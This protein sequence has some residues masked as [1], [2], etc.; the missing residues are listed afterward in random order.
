MANNFI[1]RGLIILNINVGSKSLM[2]MP[3]ILVAEGVIEEINSLFLSMTG[4]EEESFIGKRVQYVWKELLKVSIDIGTVELSHQTD[5]FLFDSNGNAKE[6]TIKYSEMVIT[7]K[8]MY[9]FLPKK[10]KMLEE[11]Y[12]LLEKMNS[13]NGVAVALYSVPDMLLLKANDTLFQDH[14]SRFS[15]KF[16]IMGRSLWELVPTVSKSE[17]LD[18]YMYMSKAD[19]SLSI[20]EQKMEFPGIGTRYVDMT[21]TPYFEDGNMKYIIQT[22]SEVTEA[23][24]YRKIL[25]EKNRIIEEQKNQVETIL[26]TVSK[27]VNLLI[28]DKH[29]KFFGDSKMK[30]NYF[31][32]FGNMENIMDTYVP[33]MYYDGEGKEIKLEDMSVSRA[34]RGAVVENE[35]MTMK[36][37]GVTKHYVLNATP[38]YGTN[39]DVIMVI[40][41]GWDITDRIKYQGFVESQRDYM[42]RIFN[43]LQLPIMSMAAS[44]YTVKSINTSAVAILNKYFGMTDSLAIDEI[45]GRKYEDILNV[46]DEISDSDFF[47]RM[48]EKKYDAI[49]ESI[50][51]K[52]GK[53]AIYFNMIFQ[54][55]LNI[56]GEV[57]EILISGV[58]ITSEVKK[59]KEMEQIIKMKDE[60]L[61]LMSHEFKTPLTV[62]NAAI[63]TLEYLYAG[64]IPDKAAL[65]IDKVKLNV[66]RE[67]RL[68]DNLLDITR[69]N[70]GQLKIR[71]KNVDIVYLVRTI[72]ESVALYAR[73]KELDMSFVTKLK[74]KIIGVDDE[75]LERIML[76]LLSNA[77]KYTPKGKHITVELTT[78]MYK[79]RRMVCIRVKDQGIGIPKENQR[80]IFKQFVQ[81]D[82]SLTRPAEGS[83]VGL[84]LTKLL[85]D[86]LEG[87]IFLTS[88]TGKG[89]VFTL[90]IPSKK[91]RT[92]PEDMDKQETYGK[93]IIQSVATELS[94]IYF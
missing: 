25:F 91:V 12:P 87:E 46:P 44:D 47:E 82:S 90:L 70:A 79:D 18:A 76:N 94:D 27:S 88:E 63:Q 86:V 50:K 67:I 77:I 48:K 3:Y 22:H 13:S 89:S 38:V 51:V 60:F 54:P 74:E 20:K 6:V 66:N 34:L 65:M 36:L 15:C 75:K 71:K 40:V 23:V 93:R 56:E 35:R 17:V 1:L 24:M 16:D 80:D 84:H 39:K 43:T 41:C 42:R 58:D 21:L 69:I 9:A 83:G 53:D 19:I 32:P 33:G 31:M 45:I 37:P 14:K 30:S 10:N 62:I 11:I 57:D 59:R 72:T 29:G 61:Y 4:Y 92:S 73:E 68:V 78:Q 28:V 49:H 2:D 85:T 7:D 26:E 8:C 81:I 52:S 5:S 55:I 64:Q